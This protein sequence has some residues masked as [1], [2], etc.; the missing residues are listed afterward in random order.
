MEEFREEKEDKFEDYKV[1]D[2][3][4]GQVTGIEKYGIFV[5]IDPW[6]DGLIHISEVSEGYVRNIHDFVHIGET[7][8]C[9]ILAVNEENLQLKLSIKNINYKANITSGSIK[10]TRRGFLPLKENLNNWLEEKLKI[11]KTDEK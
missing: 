10:E 2:I 8:Y 4:K 6:W 7:I 9:Q 1:G 5:S 3:I 11:Y